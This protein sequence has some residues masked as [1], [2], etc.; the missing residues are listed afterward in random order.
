M[1]W[2]LGS[3]VC[4]TAPA[5]AERGANPGSEAVLPEATETE[6]VPGGGGKGAIP[7]L[8]LSLAEPTVA[9]AAAAAEAYFKVSPGGR[10]GIGAGFMLTTLG[11][12]IVP[13]PSESWLGACKVASVGRGD[14]VCIDGRRAADDT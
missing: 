5:I 7:R 6:L 4:P 11:P 9:V 1:A 10:V 12:P 8:F 3:V 2:T 14:L 13:P